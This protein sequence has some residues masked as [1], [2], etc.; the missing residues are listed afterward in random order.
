MTADEDDRNSGNKVLTTVLHS[1]LNG[2]HKVVS[3]ALT[4][5]SLTGLY[6]DV[7]GASRLRKA[8]TAPSMANAFGLTTQ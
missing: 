1:S 4:H 3:S 8:S 7:I 5:Y 6:D 2:T